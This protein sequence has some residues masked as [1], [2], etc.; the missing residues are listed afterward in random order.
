MLFDVIDHRYG[1]LGR[2]EVP[3]FVLAYLRA[4]FLAEVLPIGGESSSQSECRL[5]APSFAQHPTIAIEQSR[6]CQIALEAMVG[7]LG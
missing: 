1:K 7:E 2:C 6:T 5:Y 3:S 4:A